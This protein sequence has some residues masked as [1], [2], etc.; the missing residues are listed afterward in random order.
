MKKKRLI[1]LDLDNTIIHSDKAHVTAYHLAFEKSG[2][3]KVD[4]RIL[5]K[6]FG[7]VGKVILKRL[8][9]SL[10]NAKLNKVIRDH[11]Y[12]LVKETFKF[13]KPIPGA[14]S[15]L[16][17]LKKKFKLALV[18]N[19]SSITLKALMKGAGIDKKLFNIIIGHDNVLHPKPDPDEILKAEH[20]LHLDA[21]FM[22]GDTPYDI[23]AGKKSGTKVIA[24]LTGNH[25]K[26]VLAK[27][28]PFKIIKS[29]KD[30]PKA[31]Q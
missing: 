23:I 1:C 16:K 5:K 2:L 26:T 17:Q 28:K 10:S 21:D 29:I 8:F 24:V 13:A 4:E 12:F 27:K 25:S 19:C 3:K 9:P 7:R 18:T 22:V 6:K 14:K 20:L 30:L 31:I 11:H 15:A